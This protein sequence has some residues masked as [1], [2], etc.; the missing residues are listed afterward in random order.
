M[1]EMIGRRQVCHLPGTMRLRAELLVK[2]GFCFDR[3]QSILEAGCGEGVAERGRRGCCSGTRILQQMIPRTSEMQP[4]LRLS[5]TRWLQLVIL[6]A[7][8]QAGS[9]ADRAH[10]PPRRQESLLSAVDLLEREL[11]SIGV[12]PCTKGPLGAA[13][14]R[15]DPRGA[16]RKRSKRTTRRCKPSRSSSGGQAADGGGKIRTRAVQKIRA[17][18]DGNT[19]A[20]AADDGDASDAVSSG[21]RGWAYEEEEIAPAERFRS[22]SSSSEQMGGDTT[23]ESTRSGTSSTAEPGDDSWFS[24][25]SAASADAE[26]SSAR[27]PASPHRAL[28]RA[29]A[30]HS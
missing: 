22:E 10:V 3:G 11:E 20:L 2:S 8:L 6:A 26:G 30:P 24:R 14:R 5:P 28:S 1:W 17:Q 27:A 15:C 29:R 7:A 4:S 19:I 13:P 16:P 23:E 18:D 12:A 25:A 9:W 21:F